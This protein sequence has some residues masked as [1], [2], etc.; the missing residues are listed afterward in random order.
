MTRPTTV[1]PALILT[2]A[3]LG[4]CQ[5]TNIPLE[6][7]I[8]LPQTYTQNQAAQGSAET[9]RWWQ[10]WQDP[11]L[12]RLIEQGLE[13]GRDIRIA[14]SRLN[15]ARAQARLARADM[16]INTGLS[17]Q[18]Q[19]SHSEI[20]NPLDEGIRN[21]L[22]QNPQTE[23]LGRDP[24]GG[25]QTLFAAGFQAS[26]EPDIFG[27]KR[28][29]AD[30]AAYA[31]LGQQEA[32]YGARLLLAGEIADNY[33]NA[34]AIQEKQKT[35]AANIADLQKML[36]YAQGRFRAGHTQAHTVREA[37][38]ALEAAKAAQ[39][40][41]RAQYSAYVRNIAVLTGQVPQN[42]TLPD[43][44]TDI[45]AAQPAAPGGQTP[46]GLIERRP[47]L[48]ARAAEVRAYAAKL[49]GAKADLLPRFSIQ[50]LGQG[51]RIELEGDRSLHGWNSLL[52]IGISV[53]LFTNG[54]IKAN[55][56]AADA[57][58][59]TALLN[60]DQTLL[61]ALGE[62]DTAYQS[63]TALTR[64]GELLQQA[65]QQAK[66]RADGAQKLFRHGSLTLDEALRARLD[67]H[68]ARERLTASRLARAQMT[69]NLYK[70]LGGG[71]TEES[72]E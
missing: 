31:A 47:D 65:L 27:Q 11:V 14:R 26:W 42:Y 13:Q 67:E 6:S 51:G 24:L 71:W 53:P 66:S 36:Q 28:S 72:A 12:D 40:T 58:L 35:A 25:S 15:E 62:V 32:L 45:L 59:K 38:S 33:L 7:E 39:S 55:I 50:F 21:R 22:A 30:A 18:A 60:Y 20:N 8:G 5:S 63:Q 2:A 52:K 54:R 17:G 44:G 19:A 23:R 49:A 4:A 43:S 10:N 37:Q 41:L 16:G 68:E 3:V 70:A 48:R 29:D 69:V 61:T 34:R 1:I 46:Q 57:R 9:A 56:A 64:Q